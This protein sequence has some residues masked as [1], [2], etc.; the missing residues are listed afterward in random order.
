VTSLVH[1]VEF[2]NNILMVS[3]SR[4]QLLFHLVVVDLECA[5]FEFKVIDAKL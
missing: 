5:K 4:G 2:V 1:L 3:T